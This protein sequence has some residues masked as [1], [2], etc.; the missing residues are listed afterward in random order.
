MEVGKSVLFSVLLC[1]CFE[2][3][4]GRLNTFVFMVCVSILDVLD[5]VEGVYDSIPEVYLTTWHT[6]LKCVCVCVVVVF[7]RDC[8]QPNGASLK[9][10][11]STYCNFNSV[12][13]GRRTNIPESLIISDPYVLDL[14]IFLIKQS[15]TAT[16]ILR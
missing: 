1:V 7:F 4:N 14:K 12:Y 16:N 11:P 3:V 8:F 2:C 13:E 9:P 15:N 10:P 6:L 5:V